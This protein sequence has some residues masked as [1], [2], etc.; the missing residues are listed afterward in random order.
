MREKSDI[1]WDDD[2]DIAMTRKGFEVF[3]KVARTELKDGLSMM[4][5]D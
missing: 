4:E 2:A 5:P 3:R 1:P